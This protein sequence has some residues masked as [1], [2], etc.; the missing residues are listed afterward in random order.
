MP[1]WNVYTQLG[2]YLEQ[3]SL[4]EVR[5]VL[6][7][8]L[9]LCL[10][11]CVTFPPECSYSQALYVHVLLCCVYSV[12]RLFFSPFCIDVQGS[13][14]VG[15]VFSSPTCA[16]ELFCALKRSQ[17]KGDVTILSRRDMAS[18]AKHPY[19]E[20]KSLEP[21]KTRRNIGVPPLPQNTDTLE[22][23]ELFRVTLS[24]QFW[25]WNQFIKTFL[26]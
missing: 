13:L 5:E 18:T 21:E 17:G 3:L 10:T 8:F 11:N 25:N 2:V 16:N 22:F 24:F 15:R 23:L 26:Y 19:T 7:F 6:I 20:S 1:P 4:K 12:I 9:L 14:F